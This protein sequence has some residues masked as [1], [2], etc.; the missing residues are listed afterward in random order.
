MGKH[1][2]KNRK[3]EEQAFHS[4]NRREEVTAQFCRP[5]CW[6]TCQYSSVFIQYSSMI[7]NSMN[8]EVRLCQWLTVIQGS[9]NA[10]NHEELTD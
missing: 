8:S 4:C 5:P 2:A 3:W 10:G 6:D 7:W 1:L 9:A